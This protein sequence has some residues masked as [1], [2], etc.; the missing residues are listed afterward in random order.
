MTYVW[1]KLVLTL[2]FL[3]QT[4]TAIS[5]VNGGFLVPPI[6]EWHKPEYGSLG[7]SKVIKTTHWPG[8]PR[9]TASIEYANYN[10]KGHIQNYTLE[11]WEPGYRS[12][13]S[14]SE[15]DFSYDSLQRPNRI[16]LICSGYFLNHRSP[17]MRNKE[18]LFKAAIEPIRT[19]MAPLEVKIEYDQEGNISTCTAVV[20]L[21]NLQDIPSV[22]G[23]PR[24]KYR[25]NEAY[26]TIKGKDALE[27]ALFGKVTKQLKSKEE[28]IKVLNALEPYSSFGDEIRHFVL[29]DSLKAYSVQY[30]S[31]DQ[32]LIELYTSTNTR[33]CLK[34]K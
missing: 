7:I 5:Q 18:L 4:S 11:K 21:F 13:S 6:E 19:G 17:T 10:E 33:L 29:N 20:C 9:N 1:T 2:V 15:I 28:K 12:Y 16:S 27:F 22:S 31:E 23:E 32:P 8:V 34:S 30:C 14:Y 26:D 25:I 24:E 3:T